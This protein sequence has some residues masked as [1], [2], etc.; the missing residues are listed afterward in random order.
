V[1]HIPVC[2]YGVIFKNILAAAHEQLTIFA[3]LC[4]GGILHSGPILQTRVERF[5][6]QRPGMDYHNA[7]SIVYRNQQFIH[8]THLYLQF[9]C[10]YR[11]V[12]SHHHH[13]RLYD[14]AQEWE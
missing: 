12:G 7:L 2:Y 4:S 8:S 3:P 13:F 14:I 9:V 11:R 10:A 5:Y 1:V 6:Q